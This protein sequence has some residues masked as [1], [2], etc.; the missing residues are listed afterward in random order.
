MCDLCTMLIGAVTESQCHTRQAR[1]PH[2]RKQAK[3]RTPA[4]LE[5]LLEDIG[6]CALDKLEGCA[7]LLAREAEMH[8]DNSCLRRSR[9]ESLL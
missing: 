7:R 5:L 9:R 6:R 1:R 2:A 4:N 3:L 8:L